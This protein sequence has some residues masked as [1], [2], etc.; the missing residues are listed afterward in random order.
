MD[1]RHSPAIKGVDGMVSFTMADI[2]GDGVPDA[3]L[4][5]KHGKLLVFRNERLG[6][7]RQ[8]N[9]PLNWVTIIWP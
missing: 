8:R 4:I 6:T 3:A 2:D 7:Y 1:V 5:D 9:V